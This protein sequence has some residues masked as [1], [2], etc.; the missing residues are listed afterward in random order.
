MITVNYPE[1]QRKMINEIIEYSDFYKSVEEL[2]RINFHILK[3]IY[4]SCMIPLL[5]RTKNR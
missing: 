4:N 3:S 1:T 2:E 5:K